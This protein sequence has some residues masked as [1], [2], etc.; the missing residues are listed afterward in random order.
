MT[1]ILVARRAVLSLGA[2]GLLAACGG[3][4]PEVQSQPQ[5]TIMEVLAS[6]S[7]FERFVEAV[8]RSGQLQA[9]RGGGPYTVFAFTDSG[10]NGL[11]VFLRQSLL[12]PSESQRLASVMGNLVVDGRHPIASLG[13]QP[14]EFTTRAG[15]RLT[16]DPRNAERVTVASSG[17]RA[18]SAGAATAGLRS[19]RLVRQDIE[20]SNGIIHVLD[21]IIVP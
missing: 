4:T 13:G 8:S 20:A 7:S 3:G 11:P 14:R 2:A 21:S 19:A 12:D 9:L 5:R 18:M 16:V 10:W 17:G 15:T 1:H 6:D